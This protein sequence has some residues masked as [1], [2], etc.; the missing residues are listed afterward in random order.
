MKRRLIFLILTIA[1]MLVIFSFSAKP[2][3]ESDELSMSV[4]HAIGQLLVPDFESWSVRE[5]DAFAE[6]INLP[7]RKCAHA[8]EYGVLGVL[9]A[10]TLIGGRG[11]SADRGKICPQAMG[12][13]AIGVAY[14]ASDE[15]HQLFVP[16][17]A[18]RVTDVLIDTGGVVVGVLIALGFWRLWKRGKLRT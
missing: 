17:R 2:A 14:A 7:V 9:L 13:F 1:W 3:T 16:G 18:G 8:T 11:C 10:G 12:C 5:Q 15:I 6:R 4:G